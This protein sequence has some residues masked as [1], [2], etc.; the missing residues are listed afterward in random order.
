M[1]KV[2]CN[3]CDFYNWKHDCCA[4]DNLEDTYLQE[5]GRHIQKPFEKN[6][7]NDCK[8]YK[9]KKV[10]KKPWWKDVWFG[11]AKFGWSE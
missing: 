1:S 4:S 2:F 5:E 6:E 9:E 10:V 7:H 8:S 11:G 3:K